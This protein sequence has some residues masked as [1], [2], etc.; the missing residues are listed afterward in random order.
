MAGYVKLA[1]YLFTRLRQLGIRTVHGVSG[2]FNLTLLDY[3]APA[4]LDWAGNC[5]ELNAGY[6]ADGYARTKGM[7]ALV[8]TFGVGELSAVNAIA[9]AYAEL[10]PV[11]HIVGTPERA[12]QDSGALLH[13]TLNNGDFR[14]FA[15]MYARI[16]IAQTNLVDPRTAAELLDQ[17][18]QQLVLQSRPVYVEIP[19]DMV[20]A[21]VDASRLSTPL[22][23]PIAYWNETAQETAVSSILERIYASNSPFILVD[24]ES[25]S[26]GITAEVNDF[27]CL[28][29]F[30]TATTPFGKSIVDETLSNLH[31]IYSGNTGRLRYKD[32]FES[33]DLILC[34]CPHY[35][36]TNTY[37]YSTIPDPN[38]TISFHRTLV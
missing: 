11:V 14:V 18:L 34:F 7:G 22:A 17:T 1:E 25:L 33:S 23:I 15:H 13:H 27:V 3:V 6:A 16:T 35:S 29:N 8:T 5:N 9:G 28:T 32:Q 26:Y 31:G 24:G 20:T 12:L 36:D 37:G 38:K 19:T 2:D 30:P 4:G 10:A 21:K